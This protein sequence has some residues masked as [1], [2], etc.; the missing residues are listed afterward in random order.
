MPTGTP[1]RD[2]RHASAGAI[3]EHP[4]PL[5]KTRRDRT[6]K[7][8]PGA[9]RRPLPRHTGLPSVHLHRRTADSRR[10]I[11]VVPATR[12][13]AASA[14]LPRLVARG[15]PAAVPGRCRPCDISTT[16]PGCWKAL[17]PINKRSRLKGAITCAELGVHFR[18]KPNA[19]GGPPPGGGGRDCG[20]AGR[21]RPPGGPGGAAR[22]RR[23]PRGGRPERPDCQE[24]P[25]ASCGYGK[26]HRSQCN[27]PGGRSSGIRWPGF[28]HGVKT[29][30]CV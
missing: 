8:R 20:G 25:A 3:R 27:C 4:V 13:S 22:P 14:R 15:C 10:G 26:S 18:S 17:R 30:K 6:R 28:A 12:G 19:P 9:R 7:R 21:P 5:G 16:D 1:N 2:G 29:H 11:L 23:R 24:R